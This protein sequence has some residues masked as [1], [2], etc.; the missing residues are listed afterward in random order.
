MRDLLLIRSSWSESSFARA[1]SGFEGDTAFPS[2]DL[3][4]L[5]SQAAETLG[6]SLKQV[7][8]HTADSFYKKG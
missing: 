8:V 5:L 3:N 4:G 7:K 6:Q 2:E 1:Y